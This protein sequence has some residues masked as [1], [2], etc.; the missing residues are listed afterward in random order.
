LQL[1]ARTD[2]AFVRF[3]LTDPRRTLTPEQLATLFDPHIER[4]RYVDG[5]RLTG[6]EYLIAKQ[7]IRDH[8]AYAG[9]RGC[10]MQAE[11]SPMGQ[12]LTVWFT[13]PRNSYKNIQA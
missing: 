9:R 11:I 2:G 10:R 1:T 3:T 5:D 8:D 12:G 6:V 13:L 7:V 4:M